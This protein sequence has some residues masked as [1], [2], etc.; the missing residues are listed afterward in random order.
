MEIDKVSPQ[1]AIAKRGELLVLP[2]SVQSL[3]GLDD[4]ESSK[5]QILAKFY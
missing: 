3:Q 1:L 2:I 5:N 4:I